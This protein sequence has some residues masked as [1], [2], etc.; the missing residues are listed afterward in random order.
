MNKEGIFMPQATEEDIRREKQK[1]R[2]LRHSRWW[3]RKKER[4][5][6]YYCNRKVGAGE[7][8]MDHI[9]PLIRGGKSTKSN[10]VPACKECNS[11]KKYLLPLE[12]EEYLDKI[13]RQTGD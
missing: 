12:W 13:R 6:C 1:A 8:T 2:K 4:G 3:H 9:V 5:V 11:K 7:L 10:I